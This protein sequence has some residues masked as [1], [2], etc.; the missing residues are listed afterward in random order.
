MRRIP[1]PQRLKLPSLSP[2]LDG[3][4]AVRPA[5]RFTQL[6]R[7]PCAQPSA[8]IGFGVIAWRVLRYLHR[9]CPAFLV[10]LAGLFLGCG[11]HR[12]RWVNRGGARCSCGLLASFRLQ[13]RL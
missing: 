11:G 8:P 1:Q 6:Q 13:L 9:L 7:L 5:P 12:L 10:I 3:G 4:H 2:A